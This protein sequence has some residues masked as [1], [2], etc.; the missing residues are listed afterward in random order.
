M[1]RPPIG[2]HA[3]SSTERSRKRRA[4]LSAKPDATKPAEHATKPQAAGEQPGRVK[5]DP[6]PFPNPRGMEQEIARLKTENGRLKARIAELEQ[7]P[8]GEID[9]ATLSTSA[10]QKLEAFQRQYA[11]EKDLEVERRVEEGVRARIEEWLP[12]MK[13]RTDKA[14]RIISSFA[15]RIPRATYRQILSCLHPDSRLSTTDRKLSEAFHAFERLEDV[16]VREDR[17]QS[18]PLPRTYAEMMERGRQAAEHR[19]ERARRA[20]AKRRATRPPA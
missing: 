20:A 10:Q 2:N 12:S 13:E 4:G 17:P 7:R 9:P 18:S 15:G 11:R 6:R 5:F 16:L 8:A 14:E 19:S 3:M 1:G